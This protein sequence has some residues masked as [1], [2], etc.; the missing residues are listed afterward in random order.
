M[1]DGTYVDI[2][3]DKIIGS[4]EEVMLLLKQEE[5]LL[6]S[7]KELLKESE[8][9]KLCLNWNTNDVNNSPKLFSKSY[10]AFQRE[11]FSKMSVNEIALMAIFTMHLESGTNRVVVNGKNP[12]NKVLEKLLSK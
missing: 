4:K 10:K 12:S 5:E 11:V 8:K 6:R 3:T 1:G 9:N 2:T 7:E